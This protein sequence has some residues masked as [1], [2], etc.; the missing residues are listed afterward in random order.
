[1]RIKKLL[2]VL[3]VTL[4]FLVMGILLVA[5][6]KK[7]EKKKEE[8]I[9]KRVEIT[10]WCMAFDPHVNGFNNVI[11]AFHKKNPDIKVILEPQPGQAEMVS[12]M[13]SALS[14]GKGAHAFTTPGTTITEW[15]VPGNLQP[16]SPDV[17]T[18]DQVKRNFLPENYI[19]CHINE[20]IWAIGIPD[21]PGDAGIIVNVDHLKEAGLPVLT[22]FESRQQLIDYATK[23]AK[24]ENGKLVRGGLSFQE[25]NDPM[26][27]YSYIA[28]IGGKFWDNDKQKFT[29]QTPQAK[30]VLQFFY[31]LFYKYRVD[32]VELPDTL[33]ALSQNLTS[34]G[35]MWPEFLP[36]AESLYPDLDFEF[37]MK[38]AF[39]GKTS[40]KPPL[41]NHTDT[42]NVV[43]PKYV[44]GVEKDA[45]FKFLKFLISEEGQLLFLEANPGLSPLKS[46]VFN[47]DYYK[48]GKGKYLAPVIE[49]MKTGQ[50]RYWGPFID[51]DIMLYDILWPNMDA[52]FHKQLTVDEALAKMEKELNEQDARTRAKYPDAPKTIIYYDS[53]PP[54]LEL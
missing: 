45:L 41:F 6:G 11:E 52:C 5:G 36:F 23:L 34:M 4:L 21:P 32:D 25:S 17:V 50:Y 13:R 40:E 49:A 24:Y 20:Q 44:S 43:V 14:A 37:I 8:L 12:K 10:V 1:M 16:V 30:K 28:S 26:F 19:Q 54:G 9:G 33:S 15:V 42:W 51:A 27:F 18:T 48:T 29:L 7:E 47:H 35:F 53:L 46:L 38:P 3:I 39:E 2:V 22:K 31:D